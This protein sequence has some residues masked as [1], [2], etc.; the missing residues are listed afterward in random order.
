MNSL[1]SSV[2]LSAG[3]SPRC[4]EMTKSKFWRESGTSAASR[5]KTFLVC[6]KYRRGRDLQWVFSKSAWPLLHFLWTVED[7]CPY[8]KF[9]VPAACQKPFADPAPPRHRVQSLSNMS[10]GHVT[11]DSPRCHGLRFCLLRCAFFATSCKMRIL[12]PQNFD[13]V[14]LR[15]NLSFAQDDTR[16]AISKILCDYPGEDKTQKALPKQSFLYMK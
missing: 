9:F 15:R 4:G 6:A 7:A 14:R 5:S 1:A 10:R 13:S 16:G 12:D 11:E 8:K 3:I 2:I